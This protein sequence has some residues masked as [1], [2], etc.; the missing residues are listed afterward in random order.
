M[1]DIATNLRTFLL[2]DASIAGLV[3]DRVHHNH[4]PQNKI[5]P[6]V[7]FR[8]RS[9]DHIACTD[10][11]AGTAP[12]QYTFDVEAIAANPDQADELAGYVRTRCHCFRG[13]MGD[14]TAKGVFVADVA[15]DY[16]PLGT[17]GDAGLTVIPL[18]VEVHL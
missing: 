17:G 8:R 12:D 10:D 6:F 9:T 16:Q 5:R 1:A 13:A 3:G 15:D 18:D 11:A 7:F 2:G 14:A 4:V